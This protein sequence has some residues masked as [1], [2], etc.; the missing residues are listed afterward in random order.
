MTCPKATKQSPCTS[1][2][3]AFYL[4]QERNLSHYGVKV[5]E[6]QSYNELKD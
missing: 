5:I 4:Y 1:T 3:K 2:H 6:F